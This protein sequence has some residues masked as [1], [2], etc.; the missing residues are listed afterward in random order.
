MHAG[1][2]TE[3]TVKQ[4]AYVCVGGGEGEGWADEAG[5]TLHTVIFIEIEMSPQIYRQNSGIKANFF[6]NIKKEVDI[7]KKIVFSTLLARSYINNLH[8]NEQ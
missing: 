4:I 6:D 8:N 1:P 2:C 3:V 7:K 5:F